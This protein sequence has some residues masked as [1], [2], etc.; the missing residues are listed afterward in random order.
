ML[1]SVSNS[2]QKFRN[3]CFDN[4]REKIGKTD[5]FLGF[6]KIA[7]LHENQINITLKLLYLLIPS[8]PL[9]RLKLL[10]NITQGPGNAPDCIAAR[11]L[12]CLRPKIHICAACC[13]DSQL[14]L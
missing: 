1:A 4:L 13:S 9:S 5:V 7:I 2:G 8:S 3:S 14:E 6:E 10:L 11:Y 12:W